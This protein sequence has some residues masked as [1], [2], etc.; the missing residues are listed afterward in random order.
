MYYIIIYF[1]L[2]LCGLLNY[3]V[4]SNGDRKILTAVCFW[5]LALTSGLRYETGTDYY[6]Y[7]HMYNLSSNLENFSINNITMEVGYSFLCSIFKTINADINIVFL[8]ISIIT[9]AMLFVS[10]KKYIPGRFVLLSALLYYSTAFITLD[11]SG[12]RQAIATHIFIFSIQYI[13]NGKYL[14]Y[15]VLILIAALFHY[16]S[17]LLLLLYPLMR[18]HINSKIAMLLFLIGFIILILKLS[19]MDKVLDVISGIIPNKIVAKKLHGYITNEYFLVRRGISLS[20]LFNI[21][22]F[23]ILIIKRKQLLHLTTYFNIIFNIYLFMILIQLFLSE[24]LDVSGRISYYF[25]PAFA[26]LTPLFLAL[27][28]QYK[29]N[30]LLGIF[31]I[32]FFCLYNIRNLYLD[33]FSGMALF[34]PYQSYVIEKLGLNFYD[35]SIEERVRIVRNSQQNK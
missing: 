20:L 34:R 24:S 3:F 7:N 1:I 17:I 13:F 6:A 35:V 19:W 29:A 33:N 15:A 28:K 21:F 25:M 14:K 9:T 16:S 26:L 32:C 10:F 22:V 27:L 23:L 11:M 5:T 30:V 31:F 18:M 8:C 12:I 2:A 4:K